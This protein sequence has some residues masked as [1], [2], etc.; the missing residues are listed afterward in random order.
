[1]GKDL[2]ESLFGVLHYDE[3]KLVTSKLAMTCVE[4]PNQV[5]MGEA[6]SRPPVRELYPL[7]PPAQPGRSL[8]AALGM[9]CALHSVRNTALAV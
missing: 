1:V 7:S 9:F 8:I 6:C 2:R 5:R 4:K 3:E